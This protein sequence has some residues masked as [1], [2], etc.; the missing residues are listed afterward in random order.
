MQTTLKQQTV[1]SN[2]TLSQSK[3]LTKDLRNMQ[4]FKERQLQWDRQSDK[5]RRSTERY[6]QPTLLERSKKQLQVIPNPEKDDI[7]KNYVTSYW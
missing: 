6:Y 7:I 5:I 2:L 4:K 3:H 1:R